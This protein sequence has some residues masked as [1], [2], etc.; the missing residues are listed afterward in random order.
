MRIALLLLGVVAFLNVRGQEAAASGS[1]PSVSDAAHLGIGGGLDHGGLGIRLDLPFTRHLAGVVGAGYALVGPGWNAGVQYRFAPDSK[2]GMYATALYGYNGVIKVEN[3]SQFD[4]I[5]YGFSVGA[6]AEFRVTHSTNFFR[7]AVL[8]PFRN[9]QFWSDWSGLENSS[10]I[11]VKQG[12]L[13][14]AF[15]IGYHFSL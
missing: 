10:L 15:S 7:L 2:V 1:K 8:V 9:A 6:G 3:A 4:D 13:P 11:E 5:Y 14:V 12:P